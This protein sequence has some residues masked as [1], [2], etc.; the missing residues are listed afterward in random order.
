MKTVNP[1]RHLFSL[2]ITFFLAATQTAN[3][4]PCYFISPRNHHVQ[5]LIAKFNAE[6][7]LNYREQVL[8]ILFARFFVVRDTSVQPSY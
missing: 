8:G 7:S 1:D 4:V 2:I 5:T 3:R 6:S